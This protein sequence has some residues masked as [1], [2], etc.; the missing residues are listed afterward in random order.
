MT[1]G[2][3]ERWLVKVTWGMSERVMVGSSDMEY[4]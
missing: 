3:S 4:E 1:W 2:M